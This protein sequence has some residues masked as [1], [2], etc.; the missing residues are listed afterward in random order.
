MVPWQ[1]GA[2]SLLILSAL[3]YLSNF[4]SPGKYHDIFA[5]LS[6]LIVSW[7]AISLRIYLNIGS[8]VLDHCSSH[9]DVIGAQ[10]LIFRKD[11]IVF[12]ER[13]FKYHEFLY[14]PDPVLPA[15]RY[16]SFFL[17]IWMV[18]SFLLTA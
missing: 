13:T 17:V 6:W 9:Y 8:V 5:T 1:I 18:V 10:S 16:R 14:H 3:W 12:V 15:T 4:E 11:E 7:P 2:Q